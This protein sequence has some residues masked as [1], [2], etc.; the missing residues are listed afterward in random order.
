MHLPCER[1]GTNTLHERGDFDTWR[2]RSCGNY[3]RDPHA[4]VKAVL[5]CAVLSTT[6]LLL[7]VFVVLFFW[8]G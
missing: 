1:C 5:G 8:G 6:G 4:N 3:W 7:T 2:C